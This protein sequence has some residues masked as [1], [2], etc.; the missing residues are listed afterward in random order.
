MSRSVM[1]AEYLSRPADVLG[2]VKYPAHAPLGS[3]LSDLKMRRARRFVG[4]VTSSVQ[5]S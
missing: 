5:T 2:M 1:S 3:A 4:D